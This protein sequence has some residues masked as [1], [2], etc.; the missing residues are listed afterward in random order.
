MV[1]E[2]GFFGGAQNIWGNP[3]VN[4]TTILFDMYGIYLFFPPFTFVS[5]VIIKIII[6]KHLKMM[7]VLRW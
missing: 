2:G 6:T 5:A 7:K 3:Y 4:S 1:F